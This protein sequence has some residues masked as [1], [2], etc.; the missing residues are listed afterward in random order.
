MAVGDLDD[1]GKDDLVV[2]FGSIGLWSRMN[3]ASWLKLHNSSPELIATGDLDG[4]GADDVIATFSGS[5]LWQKLNLGGWSQL[6]SSAPDQ[7]VTGD[8]NAAARTTLSPI[9]V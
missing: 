8:V 2:D 1:N 6:S 5:G 3:D 4:N 7:V 9:L